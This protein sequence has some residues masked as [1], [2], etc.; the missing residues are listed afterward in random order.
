M[1]YRT[2]TSAAL[3]ACTALAGAA[4]AAQAETINLRIGAGHPESAA[5]IKSIKEIYMPAVTERVAAETDHEIQWTEAWGGSVCKLGECLEAVESGLLDMADL[6]TPF[7]PSKLLAWNFSYFVPFGASD[8]V[9]GSELTAKVYEEVPALAEQLEQRYNQVFIGTS[10]VGNYGLITTFTWDAIEE[11]ADDK[12]A[13]AGPNIPWVSAVGIVPVQSNLNEAYTAMQTG[14][15]DGWVMFPDASVSFKLHE[16]SDQFSVTDFGVI[17]TPLLTINKQTWDGL[18]PEV[19]TILKEE[20]TTWNREGGEMT[21]R[22]QEEAL[23]TMRD[24]G[25]TIKE[26]TAE[27]KRDWAARLPNIPKERTEEIEAAGQPAEAVYAYIQLLQDAGHEF[28]RD[29]LA[30]R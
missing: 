10:V 17:A 4:G 21:A 24:A 22:L 11:L 30:E 23:Q 26:L 1:T 20:G 28:P 5:W 27:E 13:A 18:P 14:V 12:V 9:M 29:W 7:D 19:Q 16:V 15:Y 8:P 25:L 3:A 2:R 6:Q